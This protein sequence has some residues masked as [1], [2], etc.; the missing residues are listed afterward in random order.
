ME[1]S[2]TRPVKVQTFEGNSVSKPEHAELLAALK[3]V[4][5]EEAQLSKL[6]K[7]TADLTQVWVSLQ[8]RETPKDQI[9]NIQVWDIGDVKPVKLKVK[10]DTCDCCFRCGGSYHLVRDCTFNRNQSKSSKGN[11]KRPPTEGQG[12]ARGEI[13][14]HNCAN[15]KGL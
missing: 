10:S 4:Q 2:K 11:R 9:D 6:K 1:I 12:V 13:V 14:S 7:D 15:V 5:Q 8:H 3:A